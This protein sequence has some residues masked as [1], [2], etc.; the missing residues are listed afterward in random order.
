M[1]ASVIAKCSN[2]CVKVAL[3]RGDWL[4]GRALRSH[5]RGHWFESSIPHQ[6]GSSS[7]VERQL[8]KLNVA[9]SNPV[10]RSRKWL[11]AFGLAVRESRAQY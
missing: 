6:R 9:G 1:V 11:G 8:P 10:S 4:R 5:R 2:S 3:N 7:V